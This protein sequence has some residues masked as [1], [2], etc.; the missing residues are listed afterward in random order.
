ME[1]D[2]KLS[3]KGITE[4][5]K[6]RWQT[7][8]K[9]EKSLWLTDGAFWS[10]DRN[11]SHFEGF[12]GYSALS[13]RKFK[14]SLEVGCGPFTNT[15]LI[16]ERCVI[17]RCTLLDPLIREYL[18]HPC[19][20][21]TNKK[22]FLGD[23]DPLSLFPT[24]T[25][26]LSTVSPPLGRALHYILQRLRGGKFVPIETLIPSPLEEAAL[27]GVF[28]LVIMINVIEHCFSLDKLFSSILSVT[29]KGSIFVFHDRLYS[30]SE[31]GSDLASEFDPYHPLRVEKS[32]ILKF[33]KDNFKALYSKTKMERF[34]SEDKDFEYEVVFFIGER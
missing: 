5:S 28:D 3:P 6:D 13:G 34:K 15:R 31:I 22:L 12:D 16:A 30:L 33:L 25:R 2:A 17:E 32:V 19:C 21:Y 27:K 18:N 8:Q 1:F 26:K 4:A 29:D 14:T 23:T 20:S 24:L 7:A 10:S 9:A 11:E